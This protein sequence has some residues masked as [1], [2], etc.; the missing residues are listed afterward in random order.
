MKQL[1]EE[2]RKSNEITDVLYSNAKEIKIHLKHIGL[3]DAI[4]SKFNV[5]NI[6]IS[7]AI[8]TSI[9]EMIDE[10]LEF[11]ASQTEDENNRQKLREEFSLYVRVTD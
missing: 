3:L 4:D 6:G 11:I 5:Y 7:S 1:T 9:T 8:K 2:Q 10:T